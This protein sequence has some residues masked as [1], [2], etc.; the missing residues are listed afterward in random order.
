MPDF[1]DQPGEWWR[2]WVGLRAALQPKEA[3][4]E[5]HSAYAHK[6][7]DIVEGL[8]ASF[9]LQWA[10]V[11]GFLE[12]TRAEYA[13][14]TPDNDEEEEEA[15]EEGPDSG[16]LSKNASRMN[17]MPP[18]V[19]CLIGTSVNV[20]ARSRRHCQTESYTLAI[21]YDDELALPYIV[22]GKAGAVFLKDLLRILKSF[23]DSV[24][25]TPGDWDTRVQVRGS[26]KIFLKS[27]YKISTMPPASGPKSGLQSLLA[28]IG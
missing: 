23:N 3:L 26:S 14:M 19:V 18:V 12:L 10:D 5:G 15:D 25:K 16:W 2:S 28:R 22:D 17:W 13:S 9:K 21:V 1:L 8:L 27:Y 20:S 24:L 11:E 6:Q 4:R 7:A